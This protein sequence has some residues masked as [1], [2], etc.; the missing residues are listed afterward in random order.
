MTGYGRG[1]AAG[2][3]VDIAVDVIGLNRKQ[4]DLALSLPRELVAF[5]PEVRERTAARVA[6]G[7]VTLNATLSMAAKAGAPRIDENA[8]L[9]WHK[10]IVRLQKRLGLGEAVSIDTILRAPGVI[11]SAEPAVDQ[12]MLRRLLREAVESA[13]DAFD[14][15]RT[16]EGRHLAMELRK[17]A[18]ALGSAVTE[19]KRV[20]PAAVGRHREALLQRIRH[21]GVSVG[22]S[23]DRLLKEVALFAERSD[24]S[25]ELAR[26]AS[27]VQQLKTLLKSAE[28]TGRSLEFL[29]QELAR[30]FNTV[31]AKSQDVGLSQTVLAARAEVEKIREQAQNVE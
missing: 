31:G 20:Q 12:A 19:A 7:R 22:A 30:E 17:R 1:T 2:D 23:D 18:A 14:A 9:A 6:R 11:T 8:A 24:I 15:M 25:E 16:Q 27:H 4:L 26:I 5:E 10:E 29:A 21:A 28:P 13:L 3:G